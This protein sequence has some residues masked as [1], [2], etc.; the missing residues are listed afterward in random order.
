MVEEVI[1]TLIDQ[2]PPTRVNVTTDNRITITVD[3]QQVQAKPGAM[4]LEAAMEA[5]IYVPYLC[6]HT[7]MKPFAAC[8]MCVVQEEVEVEVE[9]DGQKV[10]EKQLRPP[11]ASCTLPVRP[12]L[13][14]RTATD[15]LRQLQRGILEMLISEHPHGCLTCHRIELCGPEDICLRHVSVNDRCVICPKNERCELK[16]TVRFFGME[17]ESPLSYKTRALPVEEADPFYDRD[18]NLCIVCGRCVRV[19]EEVRG[20]SAI[21]FIE[22]AGQSLVG[23]SRGTSLLES[24]CEFCGACLDVCPVGALVEREN[25]WDKAVRVER[26]VC[27]HCPVGCQLNLE[28]NKR[29]KV[30]RAIPEINAPANRGQACFKGKFG[31]EYVNH[32]DRLRHPLIRRNGQLEAATWDEALSLIAETLP[33]YKGSAFAAIASARSTNETAYLLQKFAR[34]VMDSNSV[35]VESNIIPAASRALA[36]PLGYAAST[37]PIWDLEGAK[38]IL[39]VDTNTTEEHNV[40]GVPIKRATKKGARLIVIDAR[41]VELTRYAHL[42]LRPRPGATLTLLGGILRCILEQGLADQAFLQEQCDGLEGLRAS[43]EPFTLQ[44]VAQVTGV[45]EQQ[46]LQAAGVYATSGAS[47]IL[48]ALDNVPAEAQAAQV[49][50][51]A[52][53]ALVTGNVGKPSTGLYALPRGA[54]GRGAMDVGC[55]PDMLP[56]YQ[57][58]D[59]EPVR[60]RFAQSWGS[61]LSEQPGLGIAAALHAASEGSVN[62][63]LLLGDSV[64]TTLGDLDQGYEAL[65]RLEFLV[66]QDTFLGPA[67]QRAH[68]V[69]PATT[70]A[71]EDGT[72]TNLERRVQL[73]KKATSPKNTEAESGW[74]F[75]CRLARRMGAQGFGFQSTAEVFDEI[76]SLAPIYGGI[77]H[78]RLLKEATITLRPDPVNPQPTQLLHS[79]RVSRGIQWPCPDASAPG[80]PVL[81][82]DGFPM[83]RARLMPLSAPPAASRPTTEFPL[84][85]VPGRVLLQG[86]RD[87][88]VARVGG[89]NL[90]ARQELV[91]IHPLDM[92]EAGIQDGDVV[93]VV[94]PTGQRIS[95]MASLSQRAHRGVV[96]MTTLFGELATRL[97]ASEAPDPMARVPGLTISAARLEK[98]AR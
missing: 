38:C 12:G 65:E 46:L 83:G 71:E 30:I 60:Q 88:G 42:W 3:G 96:S 6:Y 59:H 47:A 54:N 35:D 4:A 58:L 52:N 74:Q 41:E 40:V 28:V 92:A 66:V 95:G 17:L 78:R 7:G 39:A 33:R 75:L 82:S 15:S 61:Q 81:Y 5:G 11:T 21:T 16:D 80:T 49:H 77:S 51:L 22:R 79:D 19:C 57:R 93:D 44:H 67:A 23:T 76:A 34:T 97:Q 14:I 63:M 24:G 56:G 2:E 53:L 72:Y 64:S 85:F 50:A 31:L 20:D 29:E 9:R 26:T 69:L 27:P 18:Y 73:L 91:E 25:K 84:L 10:K 90:V 89:V 37:N 68:V 87:S 1:I 32:E 8:R 55:V 62:A 36:E 48:Y 70:F 13:V 45:P 86:E 94:L 43:L 98:V